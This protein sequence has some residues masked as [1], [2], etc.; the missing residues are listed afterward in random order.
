MPITTS[1]TIVI[2]GITASVL[3][4]EYELPPEAVWTAVRTKRYD[5][6][7]L[8]PEDQRYELHEPAR[9]SSGGPFP[10]IYEDLTEELRDGLAGEED[11]PAPVFPFGYD[12]RLPLDRIEEHL[13]ALVREVIDR[14]LLLRHYRDDEH[15]R[16][17]PTVNLVGHSMGGL[18][19]AG[20]IERHGGRYVNK[21]VTL[22]SPF[23]GSHEAILKLAT[24]TA[25]LGDESGGARERRMAR[26]T[27][28][29]YHLL[30]SFDG[31]LV[32]DDGMETDIFHPDA[33]Q[34]SV[35]RTIVH[36]VRGWRVTGTELFKDMLDTA[37]THRQRIS[38][39]RLST[40]GGG[41]GEEGPGESNGDFVRDDDWLAIAGADAETRVSLRVGRD[42]EGRPRFLLRSDERRNDWDSEDQDARRNTGDGTVPLAGAIPPFMDESRVVCVTPGDMG[43]WE[44][45]D[46][47]LSGLGGFHGL[48]P[49]VNMLHRLAIRF[50]LGASDPHG[51]T[52]GRRLPGV[53]EW[54]PPLDL[55]ERG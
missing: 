29:L 51:N 44:L 45:R 35:V 48:V 47:A 11:E 28:A 13:A 39:L 23:Q 2:P 55:R 52:W 42:D 3:H 1:P 49:K 31:A 50:L 40:G 15:Y 34:P 7:T 46:R 6:I 43:Y 14:T 33:W 27:P 18:V 38:E 22:A 32:A 17:N 30:P 19:I 8:H 54:K 25:D 53:D 16:S 10:L 9:V 5:R 41:E 24:G 36:Q 20:Y 21:V 26:M 4:D 37:R 12:W